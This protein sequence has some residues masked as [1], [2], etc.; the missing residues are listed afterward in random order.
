MGERPAELWANT[1]VKQA[2]EK[3]YW[4]RWNNFTTSLS[5]DFS[6]GDKPQRALEA[7]GNLKQGK[8]MVSDY[9]L[10]LEQLASMAGINVYSSTH[11]ILQ[12]ER[13]V[14]L[15]L[16]D[17]LYLAAEPPK[18]Y[19]NY[20]KRIMAIDKMQRRREATRKQPTISNIARN[21]AN[22]SDTMDVD[23]VKK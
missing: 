13:N 6:N 5:R 15:A 9:F 10:K 14:N 4:D 7:M 11:M 20:K 3:N 12:I 22:K 17:Q 2:L 8:N 21:Q 1:Y 19:Y 16:I 18:D 23:K